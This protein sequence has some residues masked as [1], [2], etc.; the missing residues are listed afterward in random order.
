MIRASVEQSTQDTHQRIEA[1]NLDVARDAEVLQDAKTKG[2][3]A[4]ALYECK[5]L[6]KQQHLQNPSMLTTAWADPSEIGADFAQPSALT[7]PAQTPR[8]QKHPQQHMQTLPVFIT[9]ATG[10]SEM[11]NTSIYVLYVYMHVWICTYSM[12]IHLYIYK[13]VYA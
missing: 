10:V 3:A 8:E 7:R 13:H 1:L 12:V 4:L 2:Q 9:T 5:R 11:E 6:Q